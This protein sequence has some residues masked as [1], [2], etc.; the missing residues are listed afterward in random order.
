MKKHRKFSRKMQWKFSEKIRNFPD[1]FSTSH[2]YLFLGYDAEQRWSDM[3]ISMCWLFGF[4]NLYNSCHR[5][6]ICSASES[7]YSS[8][9]QHIC[10]LI[11]DIGNVLFIRVFNIN[12]FQPILHI[13]KNILHNTSHYSNSYNDYLRALVHAV[14]VSVCNARP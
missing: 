9:L 13:I 3:N 7:I 4:C 8:F 2:R 14:C 6:Y 11:S 5:I 12:I 1:K 10:V